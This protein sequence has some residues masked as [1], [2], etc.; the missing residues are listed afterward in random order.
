MYVI[1]RKNQMTREIMKTLIEETTRT[2]NVT[3]ALLEKQHN[4]K[5]NYATIHK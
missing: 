4:D 1:Q 5:H 2:A 3:K